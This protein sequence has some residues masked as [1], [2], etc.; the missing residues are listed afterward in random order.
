M[1]KEGPGSLT[2]HVFWYYNN[3]FI[4]LPYNFDKGLKVQPPEQF[5]TILNSL[6]KK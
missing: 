3:T 2:N 1:N 6:D 5:I 4:N